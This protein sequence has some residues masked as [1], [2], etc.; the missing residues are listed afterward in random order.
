MPI[1]KP[2]KVI[3]H[4]IHKEVQEGTGEIPIDYGDSVD[5]NADI[6][7]AFT[8][9]GKQI[10]SKKLIENIASNCRILPYI[11]DNTLFF[12]GINPAPSPELKDDGGDVDMYIESSD[13]ISYINKRTAPE[14]VYTKVKV[15]YHYD[16]AL[17]EY[18]QNT[19]ENN[20]DPDNP[21]PDTAT[22][23]FNINDQGDGTG[24]Y[25][26]SYFGLDKE[27][28]LPFDADYIRKDADPTLNSAHALQEFLLLWHCNQHNVLKLKLP[29]KYIQLKIGD[30]IG[31]D[32]SINGVKLFGEDYSIE[33]FAASNVFRNGQQI[34]PVWMITSTNKTLTHIDV[35]MIQMHNCSD[36]VIN[37]ANLPPEINSVGLELIHPTIPGNVEGNSIIL[38]SNND[39]WFQVKLITYATDPNN[40]VLSYIFNFDIVVI[41]NIEGLYYGDFV[42]DLT[43]NGF[44]LST[45]QMLSS[46]NNI[47]LNL[48]THPDDESEYG[49]QWLNERFL[50]E[51]SIASG[52]YLELPNGVFFAS[53]TDGEFTSSPANYPPIRIYKDWIIHPPVAVTVDYNEGWNLVS[54]PVEVDDPHYQSVFPDAISGTIYSF[55]GTYIPV[56]EDGEGV[57]IME[58]GTGYWVLFPTLGSV[59][60]EGEYQAQYE[61]ELREDW[62]L[63][64][65]VGGNSINFWDSVTDSGGILVAN[66]LFGFDLAYFETDILVPGKAYWIRTSAAGTITIDAGF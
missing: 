64:G 53:T 23:W 50:N 61:I 65:G 20:P 9:H 25:S 26:I 36:A 38:N 27:Q 37:S 7:L 30:Y 15:N 14:K 8:V 57:G 58:V 22:E 49:G 54:L 48:G 60:I 44:D 19:V 13:I 46:G 47:T 43:E 59:D 45:Y 3:E 51:S 10:N 42:F 63:I 33:Q 40:D 12:K 29:L 28:E 56:D 11:K 2:H 35:E 24:G 62:N 34:L 17:E 39:T 16:Y 6:D 66:S 32:K 31:F 41:G 5:I 55:D 1:T 18:M 21:A 52:E 4:I